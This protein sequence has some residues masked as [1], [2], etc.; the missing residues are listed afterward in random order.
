MNY[1]MKQAV[2]E[3]KKSEDPNTQVGAIFVA[4]DGI[5]SVIIGS[6]YNHFPVKNVF[7]TIREGSAEN[8]KYPYIIHA[9]Q[10]ALFSIIDKGEWGVH[11][12]DTLYVTLFP[13]SNCAKLLVQAGVK[14]I[15]YLNDKYDGTP[16][17]I[18]AKRL[19]DKCN[20]KYERYTDV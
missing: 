13:C 5:T 3:A 6:G 16:D 20:I 12:A 2:A 4:N 19:L 14:H 10:D 9:E 1:F 17:N 8:T 7:P 11:D 15:V 18:A